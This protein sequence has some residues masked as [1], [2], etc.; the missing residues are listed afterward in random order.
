MPILINTNIFNLI[1]SLSVQCLM[2]GEN[3]FE[4]RKETLPQKLQL[5]VLR[6]FPQQEDV[7]NGC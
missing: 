2:L 3:T 1:R 6:D 7:V 5:E 4:K